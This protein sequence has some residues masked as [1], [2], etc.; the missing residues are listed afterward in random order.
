MVKKTIFKE[1]EQNNNLY[2]LSVK[3]NYKTIICDEIL[4]LFL[5]FA[6]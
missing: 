3:L 2:D 4:T 6:K 1:E 5:T